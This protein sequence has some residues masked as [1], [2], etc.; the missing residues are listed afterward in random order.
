[1]A[2]EQIMTKLSFIMWG[3]DLNRFSVTVNEDDEN[4]L[5]MNSNLLNHYNCSITTVI[6]EMFHAYQYACIQENNGG[7]NL[8]YVRT[9]ETWRQEYEE[10]YND[11]QSDKGLTA[12]YTQ[13]SEESARKYAEKRCELYFQYR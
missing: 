9:I 1:M 7:S 8:L 6:H 12:Y 13:D 10:I 2:C 3:E 5:V 4:C 11:F